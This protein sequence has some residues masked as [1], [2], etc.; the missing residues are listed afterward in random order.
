MIAFVLLVINDSNLSGSI[1]NV[2]GSESQKTG[3]AFNLLTTPA[4]AKNEYVGIITSS[5]GLISI[6]IKAINKASVPEDTPTVNF[7]LM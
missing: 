2:K 1:L 4:V 7:D 6:A 3:V 5:P